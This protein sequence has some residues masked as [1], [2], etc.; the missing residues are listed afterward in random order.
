MVA[1]GR[2]ILLLIRKLRTAHPGFTQT[3]YVDDAGVDGTF[4]GIQQHLYNLVV[5]GP[6]RGYFLELTKSILA[7]SSRM[8][9]QAEVFLRGYGL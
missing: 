9:P 7:V 6:P 2:G 4:V 8:V 5:R 3:C 1:Y